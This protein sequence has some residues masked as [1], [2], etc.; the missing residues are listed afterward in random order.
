[1][2]SVTSN[3]KQLILDPCKYS[4]K[5]FFACFDVSTGEEL[6]ID[7]VLI[8]GV[9]QDDILIEEGLNDDG[10]I[11]Y[12]YK[13]NGFGPR[14]FKLTVEKT[15]YYPV[16]QEFVL[17]AQSI[18]DPPV[19]IN[20]GM[21]PMLK[22]IKTNAIVLTWGQ[23]PMDLDAI[24]INPDGSKTSV[25][26]EIGQRKT[27]YSMVDIDDQT[28]NGP[29]TISIQK[30][31]D[32]DSK[33]RIGGT[34]NYRVNWY[35]KNNNITDKRM[36]ASVYLFL[37][38]DNPQQFVVREALEGKNRR[39]QDWVVFDI[40]MKS[41]LGKY[42][43]NKNNLITLD[44]NINNAGSEFAENSGETVL[45]RSDHLK[46]IFQNFNFVYGV[47]KNGQEQ[48]ASGYT[49]TKDLE[50]LK[51]KFTGTAKSSSNIVKFFIN[52]KFKEEN[53]P[54]IEINGKS[55]IDYISLFSGKLIPFVMYDFNGDKIEE[56][57]YRFSDEGTDEIYVDILNR[58]YSVE[59]V[60]K[61]SYILGVDDTH[62]YS[63]FKDKDGNSPENISTY[64]SFLYQDTEEIKNIK[65]NYNDQSKTVNIIGNV[66]YNDIN[67]NYK[68][69]C[70]DQFDINILPYNN[71][72]KW[73]DFDS[74]KYPLIYT[75]YTVENV[76]LTTSQKLAGFN[77]K[78]LKTVDGEEVDINFIL[79]KIIIK[80][81]NNTR[82]IPFTA[83]WDT[84]R[85]N[86]NLEED[87]DNAVC[88]LE[89]TTIYTFLKRE[90][91]DLP[92]VRSERPNVFIYKKNNSNE[93]IELDSTYY[94]IWDPEGVGIYFME[95]PNIVNNEYKIKTIHY[96]KIYQI[97]VHELNYF[98]KDMS[99]NIETS[100]YDDYF[101][102]KSQLYTNY[103]WKR[104]IRTGEEDYYEKPGEE[105]PY[106]WINFNLYKYNKKYEKYILEYSKT[107]SSPYGYQI[108]DVRNSDRAP[109]IFSDVNYNLEKV[110]GLE[111]K[112]ILNKDGDEIPL[113]K[114]Y[115]TTKIKK[116][117]IVKV[118]SLYNDDLISNINDSQ[119]FINDDQ[120]QELTY[121]VTWPF[122]SFFGKFYDNLNNSYSQGT[123]KALNSYGYDPDWSE[124]PY[125]LY[126]IPKIAYKINLTNV[127][128]SLSSFLKYDF[129]APYKDPEYTYSYNTYE[130]Y[131][132]TNEPMFNFIFKHSA[133]SNFFKEWYYGRIGDWYIEGREY[134]QYFESIIPGTYKSSLY[135]YDLD[136]EKTLNTDLDEA[137]IYKNEYESYN[138]GNL[139]L[140]KENEATSA[141]YDY[142]YQIPLVTVSGVI[143]N[144]ASNTPVYGQDLI[145]ELINKDDATKSRKFTYD[146]WYNY[147]ILGHT[148]N[149]RDHKNYLNQSFLF[150]LFGLTKRNHPYANWYYAN[151]DE[152]Y[153]ESYYPAST[154]GD[155]KP[156]E[157]GVPEGNYHLKIYYKDIIFHENNNFI[158]S[159][160]DKSLSALTFESPIIDFNGK[161]IDADNNTLNGDHWSIYI[162][163]GNN[164]VRQYRYRYS[165]NEE[166]EYYRKSDS[167]FKFENLPLSSWYDLNNEDFGSIS[168]HY[169][170]NGWFNDPE[171]CSNEYTIERQLRWGLEA[172]TYDIEVKYKNK[173]ISGFA[174]S[175]TKENEIAGKYNNFIINVG[176]VLKDLNLIFI[177]GQ[178][179][180][181][182]PSYTLGGDTNY[183]RV[184]DL[185]IY[186]EDFDG[187]ISDDNFDMS[188]ESKGLFNK[189][190]TFEKMF[191]GYYRI[192]FNC[193]NSNG[194]PTVL[195]VVD[196]SSLPSGEYRL[197]INGIPSSAKS[198]YEKK[199]VTHA[200]YDLIN[201]GSQYAASKNQYAVIVKY[202]WMKAGLRIYN[203]SI[204]DD[205]ITVNLTHTT[206]N[207]AFNKRNDFSYKSNNYY[208]TNT[209]W[210]YT[211]RYEYEA[212]ITLPSGTKK[213]II[214]KEAIDIKGSEWIE[215][216][217]VIP[218]KTIKFIVLGKAN[219]GTN[220]VRTLPNTAH[221]DNFRFSESQSGET[222]QYF[223]NS[224]GRAANSNIITYSNLMDN[225]YYS[226]ENTGTLGSNN[227]TSSK[228][229]GIYKKKYNEGDLTN[230]RITL[231][232]IN[233]SENILNNGKFMVNSLED[234][235]TY[236]LILEKFAVDVD[237]RVRDKNKNDSSLNYRLYLYD[238]NNNLLKDADTSGE[239]DLGYLWAG[240][241]K[242]N[243]FY[244]GLDLTP[245]IWKNGVSWYENYDTYYIDLEIPLVNIGSTLVYPGNDGSLINS[246]CDLAIN[247]SKLTEYDGS[248]W[249]ENDITSG[250]IYGPLFTKDKEKKLTYYFKAEHN[251]SD[252][253]NTNMGKGNSSLDV[254]WSSG[255]N[256][257][258]F[259]ELMP[260]LYK[261]DIFYHY[262]NTNHHVHGYYREK[263]IQHKIEKTGVSINDTTFTSS[264]FPLKIKKSE[265]LNAFNGTKQIENLQLVYVEEFADYRDVNKDSWI[266][267]TKYTT[268]S[269]N[270]DK[271]SDNDYF[272]ITP[273]A[274]TSCFFD[275]IKGRTN[276]NID[277]VSIRFVFGDLLKSFY[278]LVNENGG[279]IIQES[280]LSKYSSIKSSTTSKD[281]GNITLPYVYID[282]YET[283]VSGYDWE[284]H[285]NGATKLELIN[286]DTNETH[287]KLDF[288]DYNG[289]WQDHIYASIDNYPVEYVLKSSTNVKL[290][291]L[292]GDFVLGTST[293]NVD[294]NDQDLQVVAVN[295]GSLSG[296]IMNA[297]INEPVKRTLTYQL[298]EEYDEGNAGFINDTTLYHSGEIGSN[299]RGKFNFE[300]LFLNNRIKINL[301]Q[302]DPS[303]TYTPVIE[304]ITGNIKKN[305]NIP[306]ELYSLNVKYISYKTQEE[307]SWPSN[308]LLL[309][310]AANDG[311][312]ETYYVNSK[313]S[314]I[315][316]GTYSS[317]IFEDTQNNVRYEY[318]NIKI[319]DNT[320][321][322]FRFNCE[323]ADVTINIGNS[324]YKL[325]VYDE[326]GNLYLTR[327]P[328]SSGIVGPLLLL[329]GVKYKFESVNS[330]GTVIKSKEITLTQ[331]SSTITL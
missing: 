52:E 54:Y 76:S 18:Y 307:V 178:Y 301:K 124:E 235:E 122:V 139:E 285:C 72:V 89:F 88:D 226:F 150:K 275:K 190:T 49:I 102:D 51:Y 206:E 37:D 196:K 130:F 203:I 151:D 287:Y 201:L 63:E 328:N 158:V 155:E 114:A 123:I 323:R 33:Y 60:S 192:T 26:E 231:S 250:S 276:R 55:E 79:S 46:N 230:G 274:E 115:I 71:N 125:Y 200:Q 35:E 142:R 308:R 331:S 116:N 22:E 61:F 288:T 157:M 159:A 303:V 59:N 9:Q 57:N 183:L 112:Y 121:N 6:L 31:T 299:E 90:V 20:L 172:G 184:R 135:L 317:I 309:T 103:V 266:Y 87:F 21:I 256:G 228:I 315:K 197:S 296:T 3:N 70:V 321:F 182:I 214:P 81:G 53:L 30:W 227:G 247:V 28:G 68:F 179:N 23:Y 205:F 32:F 291:Y 177:D 330:S 194:I 96:L 154:N 176:E 27:Y 174:M 258:E 232:A 10:Y 268:E 181:P 300:G 302:K 109:N 95:D 73:V 210:M 74:T 236:Y 36:G 41:I 143:L 260:G 204:N 153:Y 34:F 222:Y 293:G 193:E 246:Y 318:N 202:W 164:I 92:K 253:L 233:S 261:V 131:Y 119:T 254:P 263:P 281:L 271:T 120:G 106:Y 80:N 221:F 191:V 56:V 215:R 11:R 223:Q 64:D 107:N 262:F 170:W 213:Y 149:I 84:L 127:N 320:N 100:N 280:D 152:Y 212:Y 319:T 50:N 239:W 290:N 198:I 39:G 62:A 138:M 237:V 13:V 304:N 175:F 195:D 147:N 286:L 82:E 1:M 312:D 162:K 186:G 69:H 85:L 294:R 43:I 16:T 134:N 306:Y 141:F 111:T 132:G 241:Y 289:Y 117:D 257:M 38:V 208:E 313:S 97:N 292:R 144:K 218:T 224:G 225:L 98:S 188:E 67:F 267:R 249:I 325:N 252:G 269:Y 133:F 118:V 17:Q 113:Y 140:T 128:K 207:C 94:Y 283:Y 91:F 47:Y 44:V 322:I 219:D 104:N 265:L 167:S 310:R 12:F 216:D 161:I 129:I 40:D 93:F 169:G 295:I 136:F 255:P 58:M 199:D 2:K 242:I 5:F 78:A 168:D 105:Y 264:M 244:Q 279:K 14:K 270:L 229:T 146:C 77:K 273:K 110:Q 99:I 211:G 316:S 165:L 314:S 145:V 248:K 324:S 209:G 48:P 171:K 240:K 326:Y 298:Y 272:I 251:N 277:R 329:F 108:S 45:K 185:N 148:R 259:N 42:E 66:F 278:L 243:V 163:D 189:E 4:L 166:D 220:D 7:N 15:K 284:K 234:G 101:M 180:L 25:R 160:T 24:V 29:E 217:S 126:L 245:T 137:A 173:I 305:I 86:I 282:T 8:E 297:S 65:F 187:N 238:N 311:Y 75:K 83:A 19:E 327:T 156:H